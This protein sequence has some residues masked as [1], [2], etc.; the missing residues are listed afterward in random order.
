MLGSVISVDTKSGYQRSARN[1]ILLPQKQRARLHRFFINK[2]VQRN[3]VSQDHRCGLT[4]S[5]PAYLPKLYNGRN[6]KF[7][8]FAWEENRYVSPSGTSGQTNT[9][10]TAAERTAI[11]SALLKIGSQYQIYDPFS[12]VPARTGGI[13]A[14]PLRATSCRRASS[15]R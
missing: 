12:T 14:C 3:P 9:V 10:P 11:F 2:A 1:N 6:K 4:I 5:G 7:F 13:S 8:F 15:I